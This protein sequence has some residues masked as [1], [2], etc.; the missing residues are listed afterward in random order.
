MFQ[1]MSG[2]SKLL[3]WWPEIIFAHIL[4]GDCQ[5]WISI[6]PKLTFVESW[7]MKDWPTRLSDTIKTKLKIFSKVKWVLENYVL[8]PILLT[9]Y[10]QRF[11]FITSLPSGAMNQPQF[12]LTKKN[13]KNQ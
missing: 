11:N 2:V 12:I 9:Q 4:Y 7:E 5:K 10:L 1:E 6:S 13:V 3:Q 8:S